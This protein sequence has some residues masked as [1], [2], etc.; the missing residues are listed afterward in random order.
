MQFTFKCIRVY[1][2]LMR[3]VRRCEVNRARMENNLLGGLFRLYVHM[4]FA[5]QPPWMQ[6][7]QSV[8]LGQNRTK[9][10]GVE[11]PLSE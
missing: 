2:E 1:N 5:H 7:T 4:V 10:V 3:T 8:E 9:E 6:V 11:G